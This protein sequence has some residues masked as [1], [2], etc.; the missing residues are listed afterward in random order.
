MIIYELDDSTAVV[1]F[2]TPK[3]APDIEL[4]I[5][6]GNGADKAHAAWIL[7]SNGKLLRWVERGQ[8]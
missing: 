7:S 8:A 4:L 3:P 2:D 5:R 1:K 6:Y